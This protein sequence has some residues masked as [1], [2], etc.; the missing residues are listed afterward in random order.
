MDQARPQVCRTHPA[1]L[2]NIPLEPSGISRT[3][4]ANNQVS[5]EPQY[6]IL[7]SGSRPK[8]VHTSTHKR[9][10]SIHTK[11]YSINHDDL[12]VYPGLARG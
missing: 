11:M 7:S 2:A 4:F 6:R 8:Q 3:A 1:I 12:L 10:S 5:K 9:P